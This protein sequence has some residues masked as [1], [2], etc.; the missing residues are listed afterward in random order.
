MF[1]SLKIVAL[2]IFL[3]SSFGIQAQDSTLENIVLTYPSRFNSVDDLANKINTDFHSSEDKARAAYVWMTHHISYDI[4]GINKQT[5]VSFSYKTEDDLLAQKRAFRQELA[6]KTL[7]KKKAVCEG[8]ATL[9]KELCSKFNIECE[10]ITGS[11]KTFISEIGHAKLPTN[12]SWNAIKINGRWSLVDVTWGAGSIDFSQMRF[13]KHYTPIYFDCEPE[14]FLLNHFP[15]KSQW[16]LV[17][18]EM[19]LKEFGLQHQVFQAYWDSNIR[20]VAPLKGKLEYKKGDSIQFRI[21]NLS[22]KSHLAYKYRNKKFG[23]Q[24]TL[25]RVG[26]TCS[27]SIPMTPLKRNELIIYIDTKPALGFKTYR[28]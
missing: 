14:S 8:Y 18:R 23:E 21:E 9:Y 19:T 11:S 2:F 10:I 22:P 25:K 28:R 7:K 17:E 12:H 20:L 27:F 3:I 13:K 24:L 6:R 1:H 4:K 15:D 26:T 5:K 16:Q